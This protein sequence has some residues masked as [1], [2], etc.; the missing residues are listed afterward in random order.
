MDPR[1]SLSPK[2]LL[3][4]GSGSPLPGPGCLSHTK[5]GEGGKGPTEGKSSWAREIN[6]A[7]PLSTVGT[8]AEC[9]TSCHFPHQ[10]D[11]LTPRDAG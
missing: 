10:K 1:T 3:Q 6:P 8:W 4:K 7:L 11:M 9:F 2:Q 5:T